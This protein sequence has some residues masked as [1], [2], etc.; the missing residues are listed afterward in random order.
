M[1]Q[2]ESLSCSRS[3]WPMAAGCGEEPRVVLSVTSSRWGAHGS[4]LPSLDAKTHSRDF[5]TL[6]AWRLIPSSPSGT[7]ERSTLSRMPREQRESGLPEKGGHG[8][9]F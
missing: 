7:V 4:A 9:M 8:Q 6:H 5:V 1:E 3:V 2:P